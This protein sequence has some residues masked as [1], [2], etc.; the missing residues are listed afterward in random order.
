MEASLEGTETIQVRL[1]TALLIYSSGKGPAYAT[2]H[3]VPQPAR[4][5]EIPRVGTARPVT[6][7]FLKEL[8]IGLGNRIPFEILPEN[9]LCR[10]AD[11]IT[12]W[13]PACR[14]PLFFAPSS[15]AAEL[16]GGVYPQ[17]PL[18]FSAGARSLRVRALADNKRPT[19]QTQLFVGPY[20]NVNSAG[21][22]CI[23]S[24]RT[25]ATLCVDSLKEWEDGF[26]S[27]AFSHANASVLTVY[28]EGFI[29]LWSSLRGAS[30]FPAET[31]APLKENLRSFLT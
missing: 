1:S 7:K 12:W 17:P 2:L 10:T 28:E 14:K 8:A 23:G 20:W 19:A 5:G 24:G 21:T 4:Q 30:Q 6:P 15:S 25:P 31:L 9:V 11:T 3:D 29:K 22:V 27:S 13:S 26:F 18:V 16:N